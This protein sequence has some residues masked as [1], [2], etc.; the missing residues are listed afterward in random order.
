MY[1]TGRSIGIF[2]TGL[3][4]QVTTLAIGLFTTP[5][6]LHLLGDERYGVFRAASDWSGYVSLLQLGVSGSLIALFVKAIGQV[7]LKAVR[8]TLAT[9]IRVYLQ[10][11]GLTILAG[12]GLGFAITHLVQV[13]GELVGELQRG[14]WLGF[15]AILLLPLT[16]FRLLTD[17]SQR[18]YWTNFVSILQSLLITSS[19]LLLAWLG[20]GIPGQYLATL[21][22]TSFFCV[23]MAWDGFKR[24]SDV[25]PLVFNKSAQAEIAQQLW[26][27]NWPTLLLNLSTQIGL[28]TDN[29][30]ISYFLGPAMVVPF[31]V[32]Q[33]LAVLAQAQLQ[34]VG[35]ASWAAL[36][37]LYAKGEY[38]LFNDRLVELTRLVSVMGLT[39]L[40]P[41][42]VYSPRF[43]E[44]WVG[45]GRFGGEAVV[46][47][48]VINGF[49]LG[50][51]S[52]WGC[53]FG[54]TGKIAKI[55]PLS[56][57]WMSVNLSVSL[58]STHLFGLIGPLLGS[59]VAYVTVNLWWT[60]LL[61]RQVFGT[62]LRQLF[63]AVAKPLGV[64]IPYA[65]LIVW[66]GQT[67]QPWGWL[68]LAAEM[69]LSGLLY[70]TIAWFFVFNHS[71]RSLW[72]QRFKLL[73]QLRQR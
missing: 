63:W 48:A 51:F 38:Q 33:R 20:W 1:R 24:Y 31:F 45:R 26:Q 22:G 6:L 70:L 35:N 65:G 25:F 11:T 18:G 61:L 8:L 58:V 43:I 27:L 67:H 44:L 50:L 36:A 7:D 59:F 12:I 69:A 53:C 54:G 21:L 2:S 9:G 49:L 41:V 4:L 72:H 47:L 73:L 68:G 3:L 39:S 64:G 15:L 34:G 52:L 71:E 17:A 28:L 62:N 30:V 29:I 40:V 23:T 19:T 42:A 55:V 37:D 5:L 60:P 46:V 16:P 14:Y 66:V 13:K 10:I 57:I 56:L 32:T